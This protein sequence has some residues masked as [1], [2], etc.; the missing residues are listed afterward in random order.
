VNHFLATVAFPKSSNT[1]ELENELSKNKN[2]KKA[3]SKVNW[4][5]ERAHETC[6]QSMI[7]QDRSDNL[8]SP[9]PPS[10]NEI[11]IRAYRIHQEHGA[12]Y[13][14]Y[15][16]DDWLEAEHELDDELRGKGKKKEQLH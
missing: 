16:L 1:T 6:A 11:Q 12:V 2:R 5:I 9:H 3:K 14:G 4:M 15:T 13:G 8:P 7:L 10:L